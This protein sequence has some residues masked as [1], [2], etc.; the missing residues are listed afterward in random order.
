MAVIYAGQTVETGPARTVL[1]DPRHPYTKA[2]LACHPDRST[3]FVSIPGT[4]PSA[5]AMPPGC[6]FA[7]RCS[8]AQAACTTR[9]PH[10]VPV[11]ARHGVDCIQFDGAA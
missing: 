8:Q 11:A 9:T 7:P 10:L 6:R 1:A 5:L 4:V 3:G 2:L